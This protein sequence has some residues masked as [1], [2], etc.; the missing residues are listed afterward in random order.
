[1]VFLSFH[2]LY[3]FTL[4]HAC[5]DSRALR[6][7]SVHYVSAIQYRLAT[8]LITLRYQNKPKITLNVKYEPLYMRCWR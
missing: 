5:L 3:L 8:I 4:D 6:I 1:M 7:T 2:L